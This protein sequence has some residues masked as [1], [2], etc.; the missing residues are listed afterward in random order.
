MKSSN[1]R[2]AALLPLLALGCGEELEPAAKVDSLRVLAQMADQPYAHP[3]ETVQLSSLT[4]DPQGR[5]VT[6]AWASCLNPSESSLQGCFDRIAAMPDP[7]AAVFAMGRG[8]DAPQLTVPSDALASVPSQARAAA[9]IGVVSAACPG[10]L[11]FGQGVGGLPFKCQETGTGRELQLDEFIV[12]IKRITLREAERNQNPQIA[13]ISFDGADW[14]AED[15]KEVGFCDQTDFFYDTCPGAQK[16]QLAV[17]LTPESFESGQDELGR[18]FHEA[19][20]IQ[21]YATEGI[22]E[23]EVRIASEPQN[24]WVARK[25]ASGQTLK[26]WFVARDNRGGVTW[27]ERQVRVR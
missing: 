25:S 26:L 7:D 2:W 11:S 8:A 1:I 4:F 24:G 6:W 14:A 22:F 23:N 12:G 13:G 3:G 9:S 5:E 15:I 17:R 21:H 19:L 20:V 16:H 10:D 27:A 18:D